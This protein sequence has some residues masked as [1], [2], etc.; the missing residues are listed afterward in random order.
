[1]EAETLD[2]VIVGAGLSGINTAYRVQTELP[3]RNYAILES[4]NE[5]GGTWAF[6]KYP[7]IRTDSAMGLFGFP[8]RPWPH[9]ATMA[10]APAIKAYMEEC[11][12][13]EGIDK[14]IRFGHRLVSSSWSSEEQRWT[15]HLEVTREDGS[16]EKKVLKAWWVINASGYYSYEKP[17]PAVIPGIDRFRGQVV[18]PQF[19]ND[20]IKYAGQRVVIIGSG[21][22]AVTLLPEL[23]KTAQS[24]T[25][26]QRS[27]SYVLAMP[28]NDGVGIFLARF[29]P[30]RWAAT[31]HWWQKMMIETVFVNL[32][33]AFPRFGRWL[34]MSSMRQLL[35]KG[36]DV[37]K[38]FNPRYGPFEQRLCF[39]PGGDFF[40]ALHRPNAHMVTDTIDTVTE[41]GILL[42][43]GATLDADMII[44]AT[45]LYFSLFS[46]MSVDVDGESVTDTL[47]SRY[48]WN[49]S[50]LEGV[51]NAGLILGYTAF[52]WTPG[53]DVRARQLIK[54]IKH[55]DRRGATAGTPHIDPA[56]RAR[57][58]RL[59]AVGLSSTY[60]VAAR[61][62]M[63]RNAG[64]APWVNGESW[65]GDV[66]RLVF[67]SVKKGMRYTFAAKAK[68][69]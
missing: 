4:R 40:H 52:T 7:G 12:A 17:L 20:N 6:W 51:P 32:L 31:V 46:G 43:S 8:W 13:A 55:M 66:L 49:G 34:V 44:T 48:T 69:V 36:Y 16:V 54:V 53:A 68:D 63:P 61:E 28:N 59:P 18:H 19:W 9:A 39:C 29:M 26:L 30:S 38:H 58:P 50:M 24:V 23:A 42:Q 3:H 62:R 25:I 37:D 14:K 35:P 47:G 65:L 45:G 11:A 15:L 60:M 57:L 1:M 22:T 67:G 21:A 10:A 41:S 27:P 64:I 56:E 33:L 2:I 5:I